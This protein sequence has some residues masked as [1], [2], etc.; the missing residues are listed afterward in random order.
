LTVII[1][2][3][4]PSPT[5]AI[6]SL[7]KGYINLAIVLILLMI[8]LQAF[9]YWRESIVLELPVARY[10]TGACVIIVITTAVLLTLLTEITY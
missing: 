7:P 9:R 5:L 10:T 1:A 4:L 6:Q 3:C 2:A 8:S